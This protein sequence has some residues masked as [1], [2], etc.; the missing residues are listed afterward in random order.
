M[1]T[2]LKAYEDQTI[3][4]FLIQDPFGNEKPVHFD[5]LT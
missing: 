3:D 4:Q 2:F 1:A 5:P